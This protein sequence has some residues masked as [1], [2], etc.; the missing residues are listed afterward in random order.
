MVL[1]TRRLL[2]YSLLVLFVMAAIFAIFYAVG[3]RIDFENF[4]ITETGGIYVKSSPVD[5]HISLDGGEVKNEA[6]IL[7]SGT[8]ID[9]LSPGQYTL[10][11]TL[12]EYSAWQ[13]QVEVLPSA[14][15]VFDS[16]TLVSN[17]RDLVSQEITNFMYANNSFLSDEGDEIRFDGSK[18]AGSQILYFTENGSVVTLDEDTKT[19]YLS[20]IFDTTSSLDLSATFNNLKESQLNLPGVVSIQRIVPYPSDDRRFVVMTERALYTLDAEGLKI[21]LISTSTT[22]FAVSGNQVVFVDKSGISTHNLLID[23]QSLIS[24]KE[25]SQI[26]SLIAEPSLDN[27]FILRNSGE[28][29]HI[30]F[31]LATTTV[32]ATGV[33]Y[34]STSPNYEFI[35]F[36]DTK[37]DLNIFDLDWKGEEGGKQLIPVT[38]VSAGVTEILWYGNNTH[39]F[40]KDNLERLRFVEI[41]EF[42]PVNEVLIS[43]G[44]NSFVYDREQESLYYSTD[45]G[46]YKLEI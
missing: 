27:I 34:F 40:I 44:V 17:K 15:T 35:L 30:D 11:I 19:Y 2:F 23:S 22:H 36:V 4:L 46:L 25:A 28:L 10:Q 6:G 9:D 38:N 45:A 29:T 1:K 26:K 8:L 5:V 16:I 3:F 43:E 18:I 32:I 31:D 14:V 24:D 33:S 37:G 20:N 42:S 13:K 41:S 39:L 12:D 7:D 21:D